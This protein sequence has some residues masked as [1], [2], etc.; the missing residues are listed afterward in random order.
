MLSIED[1]DETTKNKLKEILN[2]A[3]ETIS[4]SISLWHARLRYL[5]A[6]G[7]EKEAESVFLKVQLHKKLFLILY[8]FNSI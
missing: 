5:F 4:N 3:T 1:K 2:T 8:Y 6:I 7:E